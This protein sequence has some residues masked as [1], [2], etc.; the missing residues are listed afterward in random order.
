MGNMQVKPETEAQRWESA[1]PGSAGH[2]EIPMTTVDL[3]A[4][5]KMG[6]IPMETMSECPSIPLKLIWATPCKAQTAQAYNQESTII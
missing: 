4:P 6:Q 1:L 3:K 5:K 2:H